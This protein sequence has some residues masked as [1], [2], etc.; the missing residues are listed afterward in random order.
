[1][2]ALLK[3]PLHWQIF[4]AIAA[5]FIVSLLV[6]SETAIFG[7]LLVDMFAFIGKL[8]VNAL[9]MLIVPLIV[10][11]IITG[12]MGIGSP[13]NLG[14]LGGK[15]L[16]YYMATGALAILV[17]LTLVN[18]FQPGAYAT[19]P[20]ADAAAALSDKVAG[21]G[22]GDIVE[23]FLRMFPTNIIE[24][25]A[26]GQMLGIITFCLIFGVMI[27]KL[28]PQYREVQETFWQ[29][30]NKVM[31]GM[32]ELVMKFAPI[33]IFGLIAKTILLTGWGQ[34][35]AL[36]WFTIVVLAALAIHTFVTMPLLLLFVA[37]VNPLKHYAAMAPAMLT[38]FSTAS[39]AATLPVTMRSVEERAG[40]SKETAGFVLPLGATVNMDGTALY[41]CVVVIFVVQLFGFA[42]DLSF[43]QQMMISFL[44]LATSIG[45]AGIPSASLVAIAVILE[46]VQPQIVPEGSGISLWDGVAII[47]VVDRVLDMCRTAVNVFSDSCGAVIIA[48]LQG[49]ETALK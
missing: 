15:T 1:M 24:A 46:A 21:K 39:S 31:L 11:S 38:A 48:R 27:L 18:V 29:G 20:A 32:T 4:I 30:L 43:A 23:I 40:V 3:L 26:N 28:A 33:G 8:F 7:V 34:F 6:T 41:E 14:R 12:V 17:G 45:V 9:K 44:A 47:F 5:A 22:G 42:A 2:K 25:A 35:E 37:R 10:A 36:A 16:L 19:P 13:E 49:E